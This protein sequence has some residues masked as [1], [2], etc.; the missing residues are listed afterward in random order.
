MEAR[1]SERLDERIGSLMKGSQDF[2][3]LSYVVVS[4]YVVLIIKTCAYGL[5]A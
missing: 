4:E 1:H 2:S 3:L 5:I